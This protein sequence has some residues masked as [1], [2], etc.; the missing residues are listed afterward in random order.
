VR[1]ASLIQRSEIA[2]SLFIKKEN[3]LRY[4]RVPHNLA[5]LSLLLVFPAEEL[6]KLI[7]GRQTTT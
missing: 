6:D 2:F 7:M 5:F 4:R 3:Y 1:N